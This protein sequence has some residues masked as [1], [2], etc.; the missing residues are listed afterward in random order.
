MDTLDERELT[1]IVSSKLEK[2]I[3]YAIA[4]VDQYYFEELWSATRLPDPLDAQSARKL[5]GQLIDHLNITLAL[6]ARLIGMD[7]RSTFDLLIPVNYALSS[8][9]ELAEASNVASLMSAINKTPYSNAF[10][11]Y[12]ISERD[13]A[14]VERALNRSHAQS[15]LSA[16]A[17]SPFNV[18]LALALLFLK[19]YEL[20]DLFSVISGKANHIPNEH[21]T[22]CLILQRQ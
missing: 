13:T 9:N 10:Q 12:T 21:I 17:G 16:F 11:G 14:A 4:A 19:S 8:L 22:E 3:Q 15:C 20:H 5:V 18:G 7:S 1:R 2:N 6:R